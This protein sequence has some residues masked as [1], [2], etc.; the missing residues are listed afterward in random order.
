MI[1]EDKIKS[2]CIS[3]FKETVGFDREFNINHRQYQSSAFYF[4]FNFW[5]TKG[6]EIEAIESIIFYIFPVKFVVYY[7]FNTTKSKLGVYST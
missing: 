7:I 2:N 6:M 1:T 4:Y 3:T 5:L